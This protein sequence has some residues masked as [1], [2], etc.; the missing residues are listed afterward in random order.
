MTSKVQDISRFYQSKKAVAG[1]TPLKSNSPSCEPK[2]STILEKYVQTN[3]SIE[4]L[5][6][7]SSSK[8]SGVD[9]FGSVASGKVKDSSIGFA[10]LLPKF[11]KEKTL[12]LVES[13]DGQLRLGAI[14][15][16][17]TNQS[18]QQLAHKD[19][20]SKFKKTSELSSACSRSNALPSVQKR[21]R[22]AG[23]AGND[24]NL[25]EQSSSQPLPKKRKT[26]LL[27]RSLSQPSLVPKA[28]PPA[29]KR[30]GEDEDTAARVLSALREKQN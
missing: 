2:E 9:L 12:T 10:S 18:T 30:R 20:L 27:T 3:V 22:E 7:S 14:S 26:A 19:F 13:T 28:K 4:S 1:F 29:G 8:K 16:G 23:S 5:F 15:F 25:L 6:N 11:R 21:P 17:E 24:D